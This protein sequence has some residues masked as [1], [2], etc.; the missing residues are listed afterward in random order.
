MSVD[1]VRPLISNGNKGIQ[2]VRTRPRPVS[3][4]YQTVLDCVTAEPE[5]AS[6]IYRRWADL[7]SWKSFTTRHRNE[8]KWLGKALE[9]LAN[10]GHIIR[11]ASTGPGITFRTR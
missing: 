1:P 2:H 5:R 9:N 8:L 4:R 10:D 11:E 7:A 3:A 6:A